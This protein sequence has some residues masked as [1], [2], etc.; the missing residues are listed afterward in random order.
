MFSST[1][2]VLLY[3]QPCSCFDYRYLVQ[4]IEVPLKDCY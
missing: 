3:A 4:T 2:I 1:L